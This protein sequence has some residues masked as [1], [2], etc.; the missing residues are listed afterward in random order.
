MKTIGLIGGTTWL[1]T[2]DYYQLINQKVNEKLGGDSSALILMY[3][4]DFSVMKKL[5]DEGRWNEMAEIVGEKAK[6]LESG[7]ADCLLFAPIQCI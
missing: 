4:L 6:M 1:S 5:A 7:G 2:V 3:S